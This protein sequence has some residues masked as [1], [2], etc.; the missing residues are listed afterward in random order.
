MCYSIAKL[1]RNSVLFPT[2]SPPETPPGRDPQVATGRGNIL[3]FRHD[4]LLSVYYNQMNEVVKGSVSQT[5]PLSIDQ[6]TGLAGSFWL[7]SIVS[8]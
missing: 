8:C 5:S 4:N 1:S 2:T 6:Q 7:S 3:W